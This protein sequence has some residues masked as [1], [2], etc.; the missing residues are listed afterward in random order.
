MQ[1]I[2]EIYILLGERSIELASAN[3]ADRA[4]LEKLRENIAIA[5]R[6]PE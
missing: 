1:S 3:G 4:A 5:K 2:R 6:K